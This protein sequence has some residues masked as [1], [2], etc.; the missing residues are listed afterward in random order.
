MRTFD[1]PASKVD[2][3]LPRFSFSLG[4]ESLSDT[5]IF[6]NLGYGEK[7]FLGRLGFQV[8]SF[9]SIGASL[10][11]ESFILEEEIIGE[12]TLNNFTILTGPFNTKLGNLRFGVSAGMLTRN[13]ETGRNENEALPTELYCDLKTNYVK[14]AVSVNQEETHLGAEFNLTRN[15]ALRAGL[16]GKE[17]TFGLGIVLGKFKIN[18]AYWL[19]EAGATQLFGTGISF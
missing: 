1:C 3:F 17:P 2:I 18:Y 5:D 7:A 12:G 13:Y 10:S 6:D 11:R 4:L 19:A 9:L 15:I 16:N 14:L 8:T